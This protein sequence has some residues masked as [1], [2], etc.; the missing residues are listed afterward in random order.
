MSFK[1]NGKNRDLKKLLSALMCLIIAIMFF[2]SLYKYGF[3]VGRLIFGFICLYFSSAFIR[4][5]NEY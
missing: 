4:S 1:N 3:S 5:S 2:I